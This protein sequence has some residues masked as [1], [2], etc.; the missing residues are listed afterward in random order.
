MDKFTLQDFY[1]LNLNGEDTGIFFKE[2]DFPHNKQERYKNIDIN[3]LLHKEFFKN[4]SIGTTPYF[5]ND[6]FCI[7]YCG[8]FSYSDSFKKNENAIRVFKSNLNELDEGVKESLFNNLNFLQK[9]SLL[10]EHEVLI[11]DILKTVNEPIRV[12]YNFYKNVSGTIYTPIIII[13]LKDGVN[14]KLVETFLDDNI[15][16]QQN[17]MLP[18]SFINISDNAFLE[19]YRYIEV[20]NNEIV[21]NSNVTL[22]HS[23]NFNL[24]NLNLAHNLIKQDV[25]INILSEKSNANVYSINFTKNDSLIDNF[26]NMNHNSSFTNSIQDFKYIVDDE[27]KTYFTG[28]IF[29]NKNIQKIKANQNCKSILLSKSSRAFARPWLKIFSDDVECSHGATFGELDTQALFYLKARGINEQMAKKILLNAFLE[30][31]LS[32]AHDDKF[33]SFCYE[34]FSNI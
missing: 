28:E 10:L 30:E 21:L 17:L 13:N 6:E 19:N 12:N 31:I 22:H 18:L 33:L 14:A 23:A 16:T 5:F 2:T 15:D 4:N 1:N 7:K 26:I 3:A 24:V 29:V 9:T 8:N 20:K 11:I 27:S 34:R 25:D 32:K